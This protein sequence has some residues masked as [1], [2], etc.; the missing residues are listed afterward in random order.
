VRQE[1]A[2]G[3]DAMGGG[4]RWAEA[5]DVE[6]AS[7]W[8]RSRDAG[9]GVGGLRRAAATP[10]EAP[11]GGLRWDEAGGPMRRAAPPRRREVGDGA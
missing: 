7:G 8:P 1:A 5:A 6:A 2:G 11:R 10:W 3:A 4:V 9:G